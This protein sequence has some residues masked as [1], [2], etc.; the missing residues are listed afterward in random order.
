MEYVKKG[1]SV[2]V[3]VSWKL[4]MHFKKHKDIHASV[5]SYT[6]MN[7]LEFLLAQC[8]DPDEVEKRQGLD[9]FG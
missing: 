3:M 5:L 9:I 7:S 1:K 2:L 4:E 6:H 8:K